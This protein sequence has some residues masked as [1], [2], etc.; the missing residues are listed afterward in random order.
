MNTLIKRAFEQSVD[1]ICNL[2]DAHK[3]RGVE[4]ISLISETKLIRNNNKKSLQNQLQGKAAQ[5]QVDRYVNG[6]NNWLLTRIFWKAYLKSHD[7]AFRFGIFEGEDVP[8]SKTSL[9]D[10]AYRPLW[11]MKQAYIEATLS[12]M[13]VHRTNFRLLTL[14]FQPLQHILKRPK[15]MYL[16]KY[17]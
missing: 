7:P 4:I 8:P 12:E 11:A 1:G 6:Y 3:I 2:L 10:P 16:N 5:S 13:I 9:H 15:K 14:I 17:T